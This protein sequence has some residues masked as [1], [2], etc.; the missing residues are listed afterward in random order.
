MKNLNL[1]LIF[2]TLLTLSSPL[3]CDID[4]DIFG[5]EDIDEPQ[6][7]PGPFR[8]EGEFDS[9]A[10]THFKKDGFRDQKMSFS[11]W[12]GS[13]GMAFCYLAY[14]REAYA[15]GVAYNYARLCWDE[16]PFFHQTD[17]SQVSFLLRLFSN[18]FCDWIWQGQLAVNVDANQWNFSYYTNYDLVLWG[19]YDYNDLTNLHL[20]VIVQTGMKMDR[21]YPVV[22]FDYKY[23][24]C[25]KL[26][27]VFPVNISLE[28]CYDCCLTAALAMRFFDVRYRVNKNENLS[29]GL[30]SYRNSGVEFALLYEDNPRLEGNIHVG[31]TLGGMLRISDRDNKHPK[32][33]KLEPALYVGGELVWSF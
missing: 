9:V 6:E 31:S 26:N 12:R 30:F 18:R 15:A 2:C 19:K 3:Y 8:I 7:H 4:D 21:V 22:G 13:T 33:F 32:H 5:L 16:N 20:G 24:K 11:N 23:N 29:M 1:F 17:F 10:S 25:W 28:Y 27:A 14:A